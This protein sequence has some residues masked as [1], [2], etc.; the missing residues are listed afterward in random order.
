METVVSVWVNEYLT[1][2]WLWTCMVVVLLVIVSPDL[3]QFIFCI[4]PAHCRRTA[5]LQWRQLLDS[6]VQVIRRGWLTIN[7]SIMKGG[8][9]DYWF[10][11]TAE[12]LSWYKDEEVWLCIGKKR[13]LNLPTFSLPLS[14]FFNFSTLFSLLYFYFMFLSLFTAQ[15]HWVLWVI[16]EPNCIHISYIENGDIK[17]TVSPK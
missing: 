5:Q 16:T 9:K 2:L 10:V 17:G 1:A 7:I 12:S 15:C 13:R 4:V 6:H 14:T 11:L 3:F 8:S